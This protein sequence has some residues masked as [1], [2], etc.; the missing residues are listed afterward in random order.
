MR[1]PCETWKAKPPSSQLFL[2]R[3]VQKLQL[4]PGGRLTVFSHSFVWIADVSCGTP[5]TRCA[6]LLDPRLF[7]GPQPAASCGKHSAQ[8]LGSASCRPESTMAEICGNGMPGERIHRC[9][10]TGYPLRLPPSRA[11]QNAVIGTI[12]ESVDGNLAGK[13]ATQNARPSIMHAH[14]HDTLRM[15]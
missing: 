9:T 11:R 1:N 5:P 8:L 2:W 14:V 13:D 4:P 6:S 3:G 15:N 10:T 7:R 12:L